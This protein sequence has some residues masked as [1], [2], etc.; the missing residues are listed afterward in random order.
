M[1]AHHSLRALVKVAVA[2]AVLAPPSF[3]AAAAPHPV[4]WRPPTV[5]FAYESDPGDYLGSRQKRTLTDAD[6]RFEVTHDQGAV[7][8]A[9]Y[10][11]VDHGNFWF[12]FFSAPRG[13]ELVPGFYE[14]TN[15]GSPRKPWMSVVGDGRSCSFEKGWF[16]VLQAVYAANGEVERLAVDFELRCENNDPIFFGYMRINSAVPAPAPRTPTPTP[17]ADRFALEIDSE[18]DD[19]IGRGRRIR[20]TGANGTAYGGYFQSGRVIPW[21]YFYVGDEGREQWAIDLGADDGTVHR[22][23]ADF[24]Y[25][26]FRCQGGRVDTYGTI[27]INS[28][29]PAPTAAAV[30]PP[31]PTP[32]PMCWGDCNGDDHVGIDELIVAVNRALGLRVRE[33]CPKLDANHDELV[34]IDELLAAV[35]S[36]LQGCAT[37]GGGSMHAGKRQPSVN[38]EERRP[39]R[40]PAHGQDHG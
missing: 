15:A 2:I 29:L 11:H 14:A 12:L 33:R 4:P 3:S 40:K 9:F 20:F 38:Q 18:T 19:P 24:A 27:R 39:R 35:S 13:S 7:A 21:L 25:N 34:T 23:A 28:T 8:I 31:T 5:L 36:S 6:G 16:R 17:R 26:G 1:S 10:N 32:A 37:S 30:N 22:F